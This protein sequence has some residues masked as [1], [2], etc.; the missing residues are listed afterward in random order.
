MGG[1]CRDCGKL[2]HPV[3]LPPLRK[4][5]LCRLEVV[6]LQH[7]HPSLLTLPTPT[8]R[9]RKCLKRIDVADELRPTVVTSPLHQLRDSECN[10]L[11]AS[12]EEPL[13]WLVA[14][15][16]SNDAGIGIRPG[17]INDVQNV[18]VVAS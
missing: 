13:V 12:L 18:V 11:L 3:S 6:G 5:F 16:G 10:R 14:E 15:N 4:P 1:L 8:Q 9:T 2:V 17:L 7:L